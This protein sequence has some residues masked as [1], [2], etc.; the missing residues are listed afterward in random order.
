MYVRAM[1]HFLAYF[2]VQ[3]EWKSSFPILKMLLW[4]VKY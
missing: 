2:T 1:L 3:G 4:F